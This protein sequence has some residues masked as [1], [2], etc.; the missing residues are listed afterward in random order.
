M[1]IWYVE[2]QQ[3]NIETK[4]GISLN[5]NKKYIRTYLNG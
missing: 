5:K 1:S 3:A 2:K 4:K